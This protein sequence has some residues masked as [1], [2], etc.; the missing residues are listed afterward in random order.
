MTA[1][2]RAVNDIERVARAEAVNGIVAVAVRIFD[3]LARAAERDHIIIAAAVNRHLLRA[4][5]DCIVAVAALDRGLGG[6][7]TIDD[8]IIIAPTDNS[9]LRA[10]VDDGRAV[11]G[12]GQGVE[13]DDV[14][15]IFAARRVPI[16]GDEYTHDGI[17]IGKVD[18]L[19]DR[20]VRIAR[21]I[22]V[23]DIE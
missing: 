3:H 9:R 13:I 12:D 22:I 20:S 19:S 17:T 8:R 11:C 7:V 10:L 16:V 4:V 6:I 15:D 2:D 14:I 1:A 23:H 5:D 21:D 18:F